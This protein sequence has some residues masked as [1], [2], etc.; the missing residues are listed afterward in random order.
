[1]TAASACGDAQG[2]GPSPFVL[3]RRWSPA[4]RPVR[5]SL[6]A[7]GPGSGV[8]SPRHGGGNRG[9]GRDRGRHRHAGRGRSNP[10]GTTVSRLVGW[11]HQAALTV[12]LAA[13]LAVA[14]TLIGIRAA[15]YAFMFVGLTPAWAV[16]VL[17]GSLL[18]SAVNIPLLSLHAEVPGVE[19]LW[20]RRGRVLYSIQ[21]GRPGRIT[22]AVNVGGAV[23]PT[24]VSVYLLVRSASWLDGVLTTLIVALVVHR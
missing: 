3:R 7:E 18:G 24:I 1:M 23:I 12:V 4:A 6:G 16:L 20:V 13:A 8:S 9:S 15:S 11:P 5:T 21:L 14:L 22:V 2:Q 10:V 19:H 17:V